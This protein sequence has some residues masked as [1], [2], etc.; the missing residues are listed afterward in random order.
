LALAVTASF[1]LGGLLIILRP[2]LGSR[3]TISLGAG[4]LLLW[5]GAGFVL[6]IPLWLPVLDPDQRA[7]I[8][9]LILCLA[10]ICSVLGFVLTRHYRPLLVAPWPDEMAFRRALTTPV[11]RLALGLWIALHLPLGGL[12]VPFWR[13]LRDRQ[14]LQRQRSVQTATHREDPP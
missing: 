7:Q 6:V 5:F 4:D 13:F 10:G 8:V 3:W 12:A 9:I 2:L 14:L 1:S 11:S